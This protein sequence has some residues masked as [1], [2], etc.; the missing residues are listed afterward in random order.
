MKRQLISLVAGLFI[1][2]F[3]AYAQSTETL[4]ADYFTAAQSFADAHPR[5]KAHLHFDNTSYYVGDTIWYK[6]Y[7]TTAEENRGTPL[8][9]PLYVEL[10]DQLGNIKERQII[11]L[12]QGEGSGQFILTTALFSGYYEIRAYTKWMLAFDEKQHFSRTFP[13]Y[14]KRRND[15]DP[16]RSIV[17]YQMN[18]SMKQRPLKE[19]RKLALRFYPEGGQLIQGITSTVA[20][21][22]ASGKDGPAF[23]EGII[24]NDAGEELVKFSTLHEGMGSFTYTPDAEPGIA[25]V[26]Y[27]GKSYSFPLPSALPS[28][29]V[30]HAVDKEKVIDV[31]ISRNSTMLNDTLA[32]FIS[33]QGRPFS[34]QIIDFAGHLSQRF[35]LP[36]E[37]FPPGVTQLSLISAKGATL[38]DRFCYIM[39]TPELQL[40]ASSSS[41]L[42]NPYEAIQYKVS[43]Q[44]KLGNPIRGHFSI[45]IRDA[46]NS[47]YSEYDNT[48]YTDLL[49]TSDLKGYIHQPGYY[50]ADHSSDRKAALDALLLVRG[51][52]KYDMSGII[53]ATDLKPVYKPESN[54]M[55]HGQ[56]K[57]LIWNKVQPNIAVSI[58]ARRDTLSVVGNTI[59]DSLGYF[60]VPMTAF[61]GTVDALIQTRR[62]G[63]KRNRDA[64][65]LLDRNFEPDLRAYGYRELHPIWQDMSAMRRRTD[66][67]DSLYLD[68]IL[69]YDHYVLDQVLV[70]AKRSKFKKILAFEQTVQAYYD[71]PKELD[72]LRDKGEF[73]NY[74]PDLLTKLNPEMYFAIPN[75]MKKQP[76]APFVPK[77]IYK[78]KDSLS[79][80]VNGHLI[81]AGD[82]ELFIDHD[83]DCIKSVMICMGSNNHAGGGV[84]NDKVSSFFKFDAL[85]DGLDR[86]RVSNFEDNAMS[87]YLS[88][89]ATGLKIAD[90]AIYIYITTVDNWVPD[91]RYKVHGI[92]RTQIQGYAKPMEFYSPCYSELR[93]RS[94]DSRRTL[95]WSPSVNTD[96]NG[97]AIIKCYNADSSTF[98]TVSIEAL[99]DGRPVALTAH[100]AKNEE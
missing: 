22:A 90:P 96:E 92:R 80:V 34:Y 63:K 9:K 16:D 29:Y 77:M 82:K 7:V 74:F 69:G 51:W 31:Q 35:L 55:L 2:L 44:D 85:V 43:M 56:V 37:Q 8:S 59:A 70:K 41:T 32:L 99:H 14:R 12:H 5:E 15:T 98:L 19:E 18:E 60:K 21:E 48:I 36:T 71:I 27:N 62:D 53:G 100:S 67:A 17:T 49:L 46:L 78:G 52:R 42:F 38:C 66:L 54:L 26:M 89:Q 45:A 76:D 72:R 65:I 97:E 81:S 73:V 91:K 50:F 64:S 23:V 30:I 87:S 6:A 40:Q 57:S 68:S 88:G 47:D 39:P 33:H 84:G 13:V 93:E 94:S 86:S 24:R 10:I 95:Y 61:N 83:I 25:E 20:F 3:A 58:L 79:Y 75:A 4:F 11:E 1:S 28:G